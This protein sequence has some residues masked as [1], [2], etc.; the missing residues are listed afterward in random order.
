MSVRVTHCS[1][2]YCTACLVYVMPCQLRI[3]T[4]CWSSLSVYLQKAVSGYLS[5]RWWYTARLSLAGWPCPP[6]LS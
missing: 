6:G 5:V 2:S 1:D 3:Q 4:R